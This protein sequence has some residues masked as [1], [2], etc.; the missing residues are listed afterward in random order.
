MSNTKFIPSHSFKT[1]VLFL[2]FNRLGTTKQVFE[3]IRQ[4]KPPRPYVAA[5][6]PRETKENGYSCL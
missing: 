4:A 3:A 5:D 6:G 1:P 2:I